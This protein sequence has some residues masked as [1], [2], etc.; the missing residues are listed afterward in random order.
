MSDMQ[1]R[2]KQEQQKDTHLRRKNRSSLSVPQKNSFPIEHL[3][4][5]E[6]TCETNKMYHF[7][8]FK[9]NHIKITAP[10]KNSNKQHHPIIPMVAK[11][12]VIWIP[13]TLV[14]ES[15]WILLK[16]P[17]GSSYVEHVYIYTTRQ[18]LLVDIGW[19]LWETEDTNPCGNYLG[20]CLGKVFRGGLQLSGYLSFLKTSKWKVLVVR[21]EKVIQINLNRKD[22][23]TNV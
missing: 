1:N 13:S 4:L 2:K 20:K 14:F 9:K 19:K 11:A 12:P 22:A 5:S 18:I 6:Q 3:L 10:K 23:G 16:I 17:N 7:T 21:R 8:T 15:W